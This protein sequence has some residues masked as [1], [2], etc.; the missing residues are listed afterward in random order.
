MGKHYI[1]DVDGGIVYVFAV[2]V[3]GRGVSAVPWMVEL[4]TSISKTI[5][6]EILKYDGFY[7]AL[8]ILLCFNKKHFQYQ[9]F[10]FNCKRP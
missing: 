1:L 9:S 8:L 3:Q 6:T 5:I 2:E 4:I 7:T 10:Y